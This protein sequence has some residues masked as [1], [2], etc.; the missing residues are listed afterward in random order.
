[1]PQS[2][3]RIL[4]HLVF[5]TKERADFLDDEIQA[6]IFSYLTGILRGEKHT[7]ISVGEYT[8]HVHLLFGLARTQSISQIVEKLKGSSSVWIKTKGEK[9]RAFYSQNGYGAFG[10]SPKEV[11]AVDRYIR[12]QKEHHDKESFQ[13]EYRRICKEFEVEIDERYVWD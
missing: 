9:Y 6:E 12:N 3:A 2:H 13:D 11:D 10:I 5:S 4:V 1:M 8:D 7:P